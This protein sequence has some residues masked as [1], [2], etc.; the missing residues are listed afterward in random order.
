MPVLDLRTWPVG[1]EH[2]RGHP[3]G[4]GWESTL[5]LRRKQKVLCSHRIM[6]ERSMDV[7]KPAA[8]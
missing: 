2:R 3:P 8:V 7:Q 4:W 5:C 1:G 6:A